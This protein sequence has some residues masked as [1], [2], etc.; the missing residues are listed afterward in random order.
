[1]LACL[2]FRASFLFGVVAHEAG[3]APLHPACAEP[4]GAI[5]CTAN[6]A[7]LAQA[8]GVGGDEAG[9]LCWMNEARAAPR[10]DRLGEVMPR[11]ESRLAAVRTK[12]FSFV[13]PLGSS[14]HRSA[15]N[16][17]SRMRGAESADTGF[18]TPERS[19]HAARELRP[20]SSLDTPNMRRPGR[21]ASAAE[22][23][24]GHLQY[25]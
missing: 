5:D 12:A 25:L 21:T 22:A 2:L 7:L 18:R 1:M 4:Q 9:A 20:T 8:A 23:S 13:P 14:H 6:C 3:Q 16:A 15:R 24:N 10:D 11:L 19:G 17:R